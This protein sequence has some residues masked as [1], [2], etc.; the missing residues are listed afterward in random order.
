MVNY[1]KIKLNVLIKGIFNQNKKYLM[2]FNYT[3]EETTVKIDK[4]S[5]AIVKSKNVNVGMRL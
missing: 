5:K 2:K 3:R 1:L 4:D